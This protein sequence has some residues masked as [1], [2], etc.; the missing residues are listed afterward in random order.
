MKKTKGFGLAGIIIIIIVTALVSS[1]A[2][3]VIMLNSSKANIDLVSNDKN[4]QEFVEVYETLISKY[5]DDIDK[6]GMLNAAEEGMLNFLGDA[7]TTFL[8]DSEYQDILDELADTYMGIGIEILGNVIMS[9]TPS[10]PAESAG[11]L[12][13]DKI[14]KIN[15]IDVQNATSE[16]ISDLI[17]TNDSE[18]IN[19][20]INRN[21]ITLFFSIK[22][23][24]LLNKA[25]S[26]HIENGNI[27]YLQ[28][29]KF[30]ENLGDQVSSALKDMEQKGIN[31]LIIDV[32][33]NVGGYLSAAEETS[34]L[35]IEKGKVIYS[36][37]SNTSNFTYKDETKESR[38][39]PIVVLINH[40]SASASEI[41]AAALKESYGATLVGVKS[42]GKGKVQQVYS[43]SN[44]D[45][46]KSTTAK[47]LTPNG[48]CID[49]IGIKPDYN[50]ENN[51]EQLQK[52]IKL[53][54]EG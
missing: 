36:L 19:L 8:D 52:A 16:Y 6:E 13:N 45:A 31:S 29:K 22:K 48:N 41:L 53:L 24:K 5:Y 11:L 33:D 12:T 28:I 39:Y 32:R 18:S 42:Y 37:E 54:T 35:F 4:L 25:V 3:G 43:L 21:D 26:Y 30:S 38:N 14:I 50:I 47:W 1:V 10:S 51:D 7:Y 17:K 9:V 44:G 46:V 20:E 15:N 49:E 27:G 40:N 23:T 34:S 2:T